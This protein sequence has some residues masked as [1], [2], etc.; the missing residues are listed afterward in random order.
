MTTTACINHNDISN[1]IIPKLQYFIEKIF[2]LKWKEI[3]FSQFQKQVF[4]HMIFGSING[5]GTFNIELP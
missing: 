1:N 5:L 2:L 3:N 4:T